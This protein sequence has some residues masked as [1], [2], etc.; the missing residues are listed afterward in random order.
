VI[1]SAQKDAKNSVNQNPTD[2]K[3]NRQRE[4]KVDAKKV[5]SKSEKKANRFMIL[6]LPKKIRFRP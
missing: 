5:K 3:R 2:K 6:F 4:S 1:S